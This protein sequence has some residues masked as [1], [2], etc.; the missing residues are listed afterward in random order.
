LQGQL[1]TTARETAHALNR[2]TTNGLSSY[3]KA[4][5]VDLAGGFRIRGR[6]SM[7]K[8]ELVAALTAASRK[9]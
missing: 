1:V 2:D 3:S 9:Q 7:T 8:D 5:L 4:E 6:S